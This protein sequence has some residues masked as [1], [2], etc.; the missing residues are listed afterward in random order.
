MNYAIAFLAAILAFSAIYW[1]IA[2]RRFYTGPLI[3]AD[4]NEDS[5]QTRS[6][7]DVVEKRMQ[8][9]GEIVS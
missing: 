1:Y 2:G 9:K 6:S 7:E 3:E 4:I 5:S 8:E